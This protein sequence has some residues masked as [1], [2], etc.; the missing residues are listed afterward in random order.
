M[1]SAFALPS[2]RLNDDPEMWFNMADEIFKPYKIATEQ[3]KFGF[4][5][6]QLTCS[7]T[8]FIKDIINSTTALDKYTQARNNLVTRYA[9][10][11]EEKVRK[12]LEDTHIDTS[13]NPSTVLYELKQLAN[14]NESV[15]CGIWIKKLPQRV[16]EGLAAWS[17]K[18]LSEQV[19][20]ADLLYKALDQKP[21]SVASVLDSST[22]TLVFDR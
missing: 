14:T 17:N 12:L 7:D 3:E 4:L 6:P 2:F 9:Q 5:L 13:K 10:T 20:V 19:E 11:E 1:L 22:S 18:L 15:L 16:C 21:V 8:T